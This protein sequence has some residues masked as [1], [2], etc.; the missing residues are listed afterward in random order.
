MTLNISVSF[1]PSC[2]IVFVAVGV[3][4]F[5]QSHF[6]VHYFWHTGKLLLFNVTLF[7]F[8]SAML[9]FF[10]GPLPS[11]STSST[12][13]SISVEDKYPAFALSV[14]ECFCCCTVKFRVR[15]FVFSLGRFVWHS[16]S[17]FVTPAGWKWQETVASV[18]KQTV[19]TG[20][21]T[22]VFEVMMMVMVAWLLDLEKSGW[23]W[24]LVVFGICHAQ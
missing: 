15:P 8:F 13:Q 18:R 16:Q 7:C 10:L 17:C 4:I 14:W 23:I 3:R 5:S 22:H 21:F 12:R 6:L 20:T 9:T 11:V 19:A 1:I 2:F 24:G